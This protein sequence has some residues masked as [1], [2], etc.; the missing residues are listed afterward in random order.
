MHPFVSGMGM[1]RWMRAADLAGLRV[2]KPALDKRLAAKTRAQS[3]PA[4]LISGS[5]IGASLLAPLPAG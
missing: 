2:W 4:V 5:N 3:L 1:G